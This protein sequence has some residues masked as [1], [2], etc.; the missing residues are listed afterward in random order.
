MQLQSLAKLAGN[1]LVL[2]SFAFLFYLLSTLDFSTLKPLF[3]PSWIPI[4]ISFS[5]L[6]SFLYFMMAEGWRRLLA[7]VSR[8][9]LDKRVIATYLK[10]VIYKYAPGNVFH[11]LGRHSLTK[12]H[13][14]S[15]KSIAF[16]NGVE[17]L[18][19]LFSVGS[20]IMIGVIFFDFSLDFGKYFEL[21]KNK[22]LLAFLLLFVVVFVVLLKKEYRQV[23]FQKESFWVLLRVF[24]Y[25]LFFLLGSTSTLVLVYVV[26]LDVP[27]TFV[28]YL[29]TIFAASI[30]WLLGF[31]VPGAPGGVGIR[32]AILVLLLPAIMMVSSELV[33]AGALIYRVI[34]IL[35]EGLTYIWAKLLEN[36]EVSR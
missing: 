24:V 36:K 25:Q 1:L 6:F 14:L 26:L 17:I 27:F 28:M 18:M 31:I 33:L 23:L 4:M 7:L 10:T 8:R 16:A 3:S 32:E 22:I 13:G 20:L 9:R 11:F 12:T 35:G 29:H 19:Q 5:V 2:G 30:A 15:H 21:S 34:T